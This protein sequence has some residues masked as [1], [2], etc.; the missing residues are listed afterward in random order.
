MPSKQAEDPDAPEDYEKNKQLIE[1]LCRQSPNDVCADCGSAGTRWASV[2]FGV[3]VCIRCSGIHR[4]LG[5]HISKVKSTNMDKWARAEIELMRSIGNANAPALYEAKFPKGKKKLKPEDGDST[6]KEYLYDK[7]DKHLFSSATWGEQLKK[8]YK[9][10]GFKG[11]KLLKQ[12]IETAAK[13]TSNDA[14][15][16]K[17]ESAKKKKIKFGKGKFGPMTVAVGEEHDEKRSALFA[18]FG[19]EC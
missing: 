7:Y 14:A 17:E 8:V 11:T 12:Q 18:H 3:F 5:T 19:I 6:V 2:N 16:A 1:E 4:N 9:A 10:T 15:D 13:F